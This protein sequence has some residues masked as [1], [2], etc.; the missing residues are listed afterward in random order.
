MEDEEKPLPSARLA[1]GISWSL[2]PPGWVAVCHSAKEKGGSWPACPH[3]VTQRL[4]FSSLSPLYFHTAKATAPRLPRERA[5]FIPHDPS[6]N[7]GSMPDQ[8]SAKGSNTPF[9]RFSSPRLQ[10]V[11]P[12]THGTNVRHIHKQPPDYPERMITHRRGMTQMGTIYISKASRNKGSFPGW[13]H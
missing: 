6:F 12:L 5:S 2:A 9:L 3:T 4:Q 7:P 8:R 10:T 1:L 13:S 11:C